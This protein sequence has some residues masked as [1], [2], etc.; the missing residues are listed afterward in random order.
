MQ[1][2]TSPS[3]QEQKFSYLDLC[4]NRIHKCDITVNCNAGTGTVTHLMVCKKSYK[5]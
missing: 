3:K 1:K 4:N 2:E 5:N